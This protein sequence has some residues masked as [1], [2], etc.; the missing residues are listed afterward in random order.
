MTQRAAPTVEIVVLDD[1]WRAKLRSCRA[2]AARA[3]DAA[4]AGRRL[5]RRATLVVALANDRTVRRLNRDHRGR[6]KAT[7]VLAF[8]ERDAHSPDPGSLGDI[9]LA[10]GTVAREAKAQGKTLAQHAQHLVV[11][12]TLH[13]LGF[14]H[15]DEA[16]AR[17]MEA[18]ERRALARIGVPDPYR[19][20]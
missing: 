11:H 12:G 15:V 19:P 13:L 6:D 5:R 20:R 8:A 10:L 2:L 16:E 4:L 7:N 14:D 3:V 18:A 17:R 1:A 9:V